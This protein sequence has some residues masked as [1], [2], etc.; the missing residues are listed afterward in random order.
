M[1]DLRDKRI[2]RVFLACMLVL[3]GLIALSLRAPRATRLQWLARLHLPNPYDLHLEVM[4]ILALALAA[5]LCWAMYRRPSQPLPPA[6]WP[7]TLAL[8]LIGAAAAGIVGWNRDQYF[9]V[10]DNF[11]YYLGA[12]YARELRYDKHY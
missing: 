3:L 10:G 12:K 11:H 7:Y 5:G 8:A 2:A 6:L 9:D 4:P 1:T